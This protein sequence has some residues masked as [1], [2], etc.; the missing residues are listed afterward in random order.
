MARLRLTKIASM[1][2]ELDRIAE[3]LEKIDP[4]LALGRGP[5]LGQYRLYFIKR[6][7]KKE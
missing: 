6:V 7:T 5:G 2:G 4:K 1:T 3:E